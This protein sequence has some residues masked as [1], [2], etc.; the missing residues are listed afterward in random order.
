L[1]CTPGKS[2]HGPYDTQYGSVFAFSATVSILESEAN[3]FQFIDENVAEGPYTCSINLP[4][5]T[6]VDAA[7]GATV[8]S[9]LSVLA[10]AI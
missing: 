4:T 10:A 6:I 1:L 9:V 2:G 3:S 7:H 8:S 5:N